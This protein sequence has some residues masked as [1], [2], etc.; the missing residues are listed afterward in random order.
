MVT[1]FT[2]TYNRAYILPRLYQS[3]C[4]Q[5]CADFEWL[6]VDDGSD[7][8][9]QQLVDQWIKQEI[10]T[11]RYFK[12]HN[13]GKHRAINN[14]I[15]LARGFWFV[16]VDSDDY[17]TPDAVEWIIKTGDQIKNNPT[18]CGLSAIRISPEGYKIG[19]G[20]DFGAIDANAIDIRLKY[21]IK[22]DMAEVFKTDVLRNFK[23]PEFDGEKFC[24]EA[25][26]WFR[27]ARKY[28]MRFVYKGIYVC[29]YLSDGLTA[30]ITRLR[31]EAPQASMIYYSEHFH[32]AIPLKWRIKAAINFWR[33]A[34]ADYKREYNMLS[35]LSLIAWLPGMCMR[36]IDKVK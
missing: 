6:I 33:F 31:R 3:L 35:S 22:G 7:D 21:N 10:I 15:E 13:G 28:E 24:P 34:L 26:V 20:D 36:L 17:L 4:N 8:H 27:L 25:L 2:P 16:I 9:T 5:S 32:D 18:F 1:V 14:G 23:F 12:Q 29:K 30:K 19:G 11:I